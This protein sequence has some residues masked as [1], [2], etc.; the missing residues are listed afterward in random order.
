M[1][2]ISQDTYSIPVRICII[3]ILIIY[4]TLKQIISQLFHSCMN[5]MTGLHSNKQQNRK[6]QKVAVIGGGIAGHSCCFTLSMCPDQFEPILF[7]TRG[8]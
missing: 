6:K 3:L 7:E 1:K 5:I 4:N 2:K 8:T